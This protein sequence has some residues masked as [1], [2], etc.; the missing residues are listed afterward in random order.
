MRKLE[1]FLRTKKLEVQHR[2][3]TE[4]AA[5]ALEQQ[6]NGGGAAAG[7]AAATGPPPPVVGAAA[8]SDEPERC[9]RAGCERCRL[10]IACGPT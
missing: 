10:S 4:A 1:A 3:V 6:P 2:A 9:G 8:V 7:G 5:A